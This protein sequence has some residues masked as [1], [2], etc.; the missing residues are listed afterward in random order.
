MCTVQQQLCAQVVLRKRASCENGASKINI[1]KYYENL[2][3]N[4]QISLL[5]VQYY[6]SV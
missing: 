6:G 1:R 4:R 2:V 3:A 5:N